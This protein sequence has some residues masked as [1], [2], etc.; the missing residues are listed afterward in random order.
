MLT[1]RLLRFKAEGKD[2]LIYDHPTEA[3]SVVFDR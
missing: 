2:V 1:I 3:G